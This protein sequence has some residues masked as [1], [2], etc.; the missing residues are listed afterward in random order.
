MYL[1]NGQM[2]STEQIN[3]LPIVAVLIAGSFLAILNQT[4][5]ATAIPHI[6]I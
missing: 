5:L 4:L 6:M 2:G 1:K 3:R